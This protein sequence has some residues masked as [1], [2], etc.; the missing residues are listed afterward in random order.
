MHRRFEI[1]FGLCTVTDFLLRLLSSNTDF[2]QILFAALA[3]LLLKSK[4][5]GVVSPDFAN[6]LGLQTAD[7][8]NQMIFS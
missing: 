2:F 5:R 8:K 6:L 3:A 4:A 1:A 7:T